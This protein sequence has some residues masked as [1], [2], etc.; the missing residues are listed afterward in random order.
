MVVLVVVVLL[1]YVLTV[2]CKYEGQRASIATGFPIIITLQEE[3]EN[4]NKIRGMRIT[5]C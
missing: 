1:V 3:R 4:L 2:I 5:A